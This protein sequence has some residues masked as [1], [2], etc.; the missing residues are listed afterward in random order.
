MA[1]DVRLFLA[2]QPQVSDLTAHNVTGQDVGNSLQWKDHKG[3]IRLGV[4]M[5]EDVHHLLPN[6]SFVILCGSFLQSMWLQLHICLHIHMQHK[7]E[8]LPQVLSTIV[9]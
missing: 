6:H 3:H 7:S 8:V 5:A 2:N 1:E 9:V 4:A